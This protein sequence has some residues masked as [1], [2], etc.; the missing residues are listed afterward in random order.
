M[1]NTELGIAIAIAILLQLF[2]W[3]LQIRKY[4]I[5]AVKPTYLYVS[6]TERTFEEQNMLPL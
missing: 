4:T 3:I 2:L 5:D 1:R 6:F